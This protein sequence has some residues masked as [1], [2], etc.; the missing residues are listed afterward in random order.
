[1]ASEGY[2]SSYPYKTKR[3]VFHGVYYISPVLLN[4][5]TFGRISNTK[6]ISK[7]AGGDRGTLASRDV[8]TQVELLNFYQRETESE[9]SH[10]TV[11]GNVVKVS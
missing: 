11:V 9:R 2:L 8:P 4:Y 7:L 6:Y 5:F 10:D 1:M 3:K